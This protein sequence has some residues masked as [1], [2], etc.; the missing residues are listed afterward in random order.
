[1]NELPKI[2]C[3]MKRNV[4]FVGVNTTLGEAVRLMVDKK[5]GTLPIVDET[6]L[7]AGVTTI[8][9]I[10]QIFLPDFVALLS[11]IDFVKDFGSL[12][13]PSQETMNKEE[14]RLVSEIMAEPIAV[15]D[16]SSLIRAL[17]IMHKHNLADLPV[18]KQGILVGISSRVDIGRAF[19]AD[20][21]SGSMI[22]QEGN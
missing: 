19:F 15:E 20:W 17:A 4:V 9:D 8:S 6:G 3:C 22:D 13:Y 2:N 16:D 5:V 1:M 12:K 21:R 10:I 7:L 18:L 11:D 14:K